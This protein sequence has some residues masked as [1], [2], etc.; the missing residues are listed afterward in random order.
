MGSGGEAIDA[1][2]PAID[3]LRALA[4]EAPVIRLVSMLLSE[5]L[6]ARASDVH[7]EAYPDALRVRYRVDGVLHSIGF[8]PASCL[9]E[10][11]FLKAPWEDVATTIQVSAYSFKSLA[12]ATLPLLGPAW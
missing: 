10:G 7:L 2:S 4:N 11:A 8:A 12:V 1:E 3:D 9:G 6:A 5:A